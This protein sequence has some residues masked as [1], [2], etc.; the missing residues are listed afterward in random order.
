MYVLSVKGMTKTFKG[1]YYVTASGDEIGFSTASS[2][3]I[4]FETA[5]EALAW[6]EEHYVALLHEMLVNKIRFQASTLA[7]RKM[8]YKTIFTVDQETF[9]KVRSQKLTAAVVEG[10]NDEEIK[11]TVD[12]FDE[13]SYHELEHEPAVEAEVPVYADEASSSDLSEDDIES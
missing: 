7:V 9:D 4:D 1:F 3:A 6:A 12:A 13:I 10:A 8:V 11:E 2:D 5:E